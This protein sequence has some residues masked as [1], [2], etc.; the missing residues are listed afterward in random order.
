MVVT[1]VEESGSLRVSPSG[2]LYPWKLGE[3]AV[4]VLGDVQTLVGVLSMGSGHAPNLEKRP[5]EWESVFIRT[6]LSKEAVNDAGVRPGTPAVPAA[7][8]RGPVIFGDPHDPMIGAWTFDNRVS[9]VAV[10]RMLATLREEEIEPAH[11]WMVAFT[12]HEETG[13]HGAKSLAHR[14]R[15]EVVFAIDGCPIMPGIDV[16]LDGRLGIRSKD[17]VAIYDQRL[18]RQALCVAERANVA[19]EPIVYARSSTEAAQIF[20]MGGAARVASLGAVRANSH[21]YEV[22]RHATFD[23]LTRLLVDLVQ[24]RF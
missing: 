12:T 17:P 5:I 6:G 10:L 18:L 1:A 24:E 20:A 7:A 19:L 2:G 16:A 9:V 13:C 14:L 15:A 21:G 22:M 8:R 4:D 11:P 23:N 3:G